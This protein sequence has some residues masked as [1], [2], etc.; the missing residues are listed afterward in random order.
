LAAVRG[1]DIWVIEPPPRNPTRITFDATQDNSSPVWSPQGER[2]VFASHR[3][4][5]WGLYVTQADGSGTD[6]E[7][8]LESELPKAP[9]SWSPD[10]KRLVYWMQD[11][12]TQGDLWI[13]PLEGDKKPVPFLTSSK[14]ETHAQISPDGKW[15]A[16]TSELTGR[17]EVYVQ[18]FPAGTGRWQISP[19]NGL[20]GDWPRWRK[21]SQELYYHALGNA[22]AY[23]VY[24]NGATILGPIYL[25]SIKAT[26]GSI[27]PGIP[28]ELVRML[29]VRIPHSGAD[30]HTFAVS[31]DG[32]RFLLFQ[33]ALTT[34]TVTSQ[35]GPEI[36][37]QGLTVAMNLKALRQR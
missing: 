7:L 8:L 35:I 24:T 4:G 26:G 30:Y 20:G 18:P 15:I 2:I 32:M 27:E 21:D 5:K 11:P 34:G 17:K 33:R 37:I 6:G 9:M 14:N 1:G 25:A 23:G 36:P 3:N 29:A 10:G 31:Q 19:D 22:G 12:K 28:T 13:L 16:Y